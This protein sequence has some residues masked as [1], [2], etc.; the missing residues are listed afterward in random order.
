MTL[1]GCSR[2]L[3]INQGSFV[4]QGAFDK[5][6]RHFY[7]HIWEE[8]S[9]THIYV[10]CPTMLRAARATKNYPTQN[11]NSAKIEKNCSGGKD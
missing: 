10:N 7:Y 8:G 3:V 9:A 5:V 11:V 4:S 6:W 1:S 2:A